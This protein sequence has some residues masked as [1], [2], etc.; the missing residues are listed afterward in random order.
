MVYTLTEAYQ[1]PIYRFKCPACGKTTG[2]LP[3]FIGKN[4]RVAWDVQEQAVKQQATGRSLAQ[5]ADTLRASGGPYSDKSLWRWA[6]GWNKR[7]KD[8]GP[9]VWEHVLSFVP[10][11]QIPVGTAKP[12]SEWGWLFNIWD[13]M[14]EMYPQS[15][16]ESLMNWFYRQ[17]CSLSVASG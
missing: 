1:I 17:H 9:V 4:E 13:Q 10:H 3:S 8:L 16:A 2:L 7:L 6:S 15:T 11:L 5:V 12:H 14:M